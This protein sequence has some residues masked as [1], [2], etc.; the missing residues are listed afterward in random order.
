MSTLAPGFLETINAAA[1]TGKTLS[2]ALAY[3]PS[4]PWD[5]T[6]DYA[7]VS[8]FLIADGTVGTAW[9]EIEPAEEDFTLTSTGISSGIYPVT[10][11]RNSS[12][13][14]LQFTHVVVLEPIAGPSWR[15][16]SWQ[17]GAAGGAA[18]NVPAGQ[19]VEVAV[20]LGH[21]R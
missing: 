1:W 7:D 5:D 6:Y 20:R 19:V 10:F 14:P 4:D 21:G 9:Q 11:T 15:L 2:V 16:V 3:S 8:G 17:L 13:T 18:V 12:A